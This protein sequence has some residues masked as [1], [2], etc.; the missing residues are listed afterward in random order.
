MKCLMSET[1]DGIVRV[2]LRCT[3]WGGMCR[4]IIRSW[5]VRCREC[6]EGG[7]MCDAKSCQFSS[8]S[9]PHSATRHLQIRWDAFYWSILLLREMIIKMTS[10]KYWRQSELSTEISAYKS[11][12]TGLFKLA[13]PAQQ[14]QMLHLAGAWWWHTF[15]S[16]SKHCPRYV[17]KA[18]KSRAVE[19]QIYWDNTLPTKWNLL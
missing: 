2:I 16:I 7:S 4:M 15:L 14:Y 3:E 1:S 18:T 12:H 19:L 8:A 11:R 17:N 10:W 9:V 6:E 13:L 5:T